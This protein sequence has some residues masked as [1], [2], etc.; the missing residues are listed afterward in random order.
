MG[1]TAG[2]PGQLGMRRPSSSAGRPTHFTW[3]RP[4]AAGLLAVTAAT[5]FAQDLR[6]PFTGRWFVFQAGDTLNVNHHMAV[7]AQWYGVDFARLGGPSGRELSTPRPTRLEDFFCWNQPVLSPVQGQVS[8]V[9]GQ[10]PDNPL[11]SKDTERPAGNHV[12]IVTPQGRHVVVAHF[13]QG[14]VRVE[15][16]QRVEAGQALGRCG[17]SGNSDFPHVHVH[18]QDGPGPDATGQ[19]PVFSGLDVELNGRRFDDVTWP[20]IRGLFV[21]AR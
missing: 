7:R 11:G 13:R 10:L 21:T 17:N 15:P 14:S 8:A 2:D 3:R 19:N 9:V 6:V 5:A 4:L 1:P 16:G 20:L 18:V 12:V